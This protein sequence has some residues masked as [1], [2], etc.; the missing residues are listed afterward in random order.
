MTIRFAHPEHVAAEEFVDGTV[1][2]LPGAGTLHHLDPVA[3]DVW[4]A[5]RD[6]AVED[7]IGDLAARHRADVDVV[8]RDVRILLRRL[9]SAGLLVRRGPP[10][11]SRR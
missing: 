8:R 2:Y 5:V 7:V 11:T 10:P 4:L 6:R 9:S 1:V 3:A